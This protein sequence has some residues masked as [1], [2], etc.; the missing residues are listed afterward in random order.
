[1]SH[2]I[3]NYFGAICVALAL[4]A[5]T[6]PAI[7]AETTIDQKGL[8]FVPDAVTINTGDKIRFTNSDRFYH[9]VTIVNP[10]G[11]VRDE[12]LMD[13][14]EEFAMTFAKPGIYKIHDRLHPAMTGVI[15]VK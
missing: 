8:K 7:A 1:M 2:G 4:S 10:D 15:T 5:V 14:K 12:G 13:Y 9:D 11:S 3:N 6:L